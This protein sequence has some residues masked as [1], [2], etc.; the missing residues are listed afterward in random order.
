ME[1]SIAAQGEKKAGFTFFHV[2]VKHRRL[3]NYV[4]RTL[5]HTLNQYTQS[6]PIQLMQSSPSPLIQSLPP[7]THSVLPLPTCAVIPLLTYS[8]IPP[9]TKSFISPHPLSHP[10]PHSLS[11]TWQF[12]YSS[13][14]TEVLGWSQGE[15]P[16]Y[17]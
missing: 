11:F 6:C 12:L 9:P 13:Q 14:G 4:I 15:G 8:F 5:S 7:V 16:I 10:T 17:K 3:N 2:G 1:I